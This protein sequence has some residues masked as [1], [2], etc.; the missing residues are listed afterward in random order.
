MK[1]E[2]GIRTHWTP[3]LRHGV[4]NFQQAPVERWSEGLAMTQHFLYVKTP[5]F[6]L[7]IAKWIIQCLIHFCPDTKGTPRVSRHSQTS[8]LPR[9]WRTRARA[10]RLKGPA[11]ELS[12]KKMGKDTLLCWEDSLYCSRFA[13]FLLGRKK[14]EITSGMPLLNFNAQIPSMCRLCPCPNPYF[15]CGTK[16][17]KLQCGFRRHFPCRVSIGTKASPVSAHC[18]QPPQHPAI[19]SLTAQSLKGPRGIEILSLLANAEKREK[20]KGPVAVASEMNR[21]PKL[22][23]LILLEFSNFKFQPFSKHVSIPLMVQKHQTTSW[24]W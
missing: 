15:S 14:F 8:N 23:G 3:D 21:L 16:N 1:L 7:P 13:R 12:R 5:F 2:I 20:G 19:T 11:S 18:L 10:P 24:G 4:K 9:A 22:Y 17:T 6:H